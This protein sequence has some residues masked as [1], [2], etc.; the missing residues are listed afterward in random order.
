MEEKEREVLPCVLGVSLLL[1]GFL[2]LAGSAAAELSSTYSASA[3][4]SLAQCLPSVPDIANAL[5]A[6]DFQSLNLSPHTGF[7][8]DPL[9][10]LSESPQIIDSQSYIKAAEG[11]CREIAN[12]AGFDGVRQVMG[13]VLS[14]AYAVFK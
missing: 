13:N 5:A 10:L 7:G 12:R 9:T 1:L 4:L 8:P 2:V 14:H 11:V 3:S 6:P